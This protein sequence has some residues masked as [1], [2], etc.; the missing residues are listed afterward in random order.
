MAKI[1]SWVQL[2][3]VAESE[4]EVLGEGHLAAEEDFAGWSRVHAGV[5]RHPVHT[6]HDEVD[7]PGD[8]KMGKKV[9]KRVYYST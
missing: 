5:A 3:I 8:E 4:G 6:A 7:E 2:H 9:G 1:A